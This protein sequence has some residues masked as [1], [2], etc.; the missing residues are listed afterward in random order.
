MTTADLHRE[1]PST[2]PVAPLEPDIVVPPGFWTRDSGHFSQPISPLARSFYPRMISEAAT[3][4]FREYGLLLER[5]DVA[6]I[7]GWVY[8]R[9]VPIGG[10]EGPPP[11]GWLLGLLA[12]VVPSLR[13]AAR[14]ARRAEQQEL[15]RITIERW[16]HEERAEFFAEIERL[17][18]IDIAAMSDRQLLTHLDRLESFLAHGTLVHFKLAVPHMQA[19]TALVFFCREHLGWEPAQVNELTVGLSEM[20]TEPAKRLAKL[21]DLVRQKPALYQKLE[22]EKVDLAQLQ[23]VDAEFAQASE[24][25]LARFGCRALGEDIAEPTLGESTHL[26]IDAL[27]GQLA[28]GYNPIQVAAQLTARRR[29]AAEAAREQLAGQPSVPAEFDRLLAYAERAYPVRED[30]IFPTCNAPQGLLRYCVFEAARRLVKRALLDTQDDVLFLGL[31]EIKQSVVEGLAR[32]ALVIRRKRERLWEEAHRGPRTYGDDPGPPPDLWALPEP[33]RHAMR[34]LQWFIANDIDAQPTGGVPEDTRNLLPGIGAS[35]GQYTGPVC[36]IR[37]EADFHRLRPGDVLV[38]PITSP[39]WSILFSYAGALITDIGGILS[40]PAIVAREYGLP[41][42]LA[43]GNATTVLQDGQMVTV[44]GRAGHVVIH[45]ADTGDNDG[46][47]STLSQSV[48][49]PTP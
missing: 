18:Q 28:R 7:G 16:W 24:A 49:T 34:T 12:R 23:A 35:A 8:L 1:A 26:L 10:K 46:A 4:A 19:V 45:N 32:Q 21:V 48:S 27:K 17:Q 40:H 9:I 11:P 41:A 3:T 25:Y 20:S 37:R 13:A 42:V 14:R 39:V 44:D 22:S 5:L 36:V 15:G 6:V 30:N 33:V 2:T 31:A 29:A 38:C 43:T 47:S